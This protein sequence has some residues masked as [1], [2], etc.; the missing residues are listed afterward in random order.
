VITHQRGDLETSFDRVLE[1][2]DGKLHLALL[3]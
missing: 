1:L 3:S 2:R